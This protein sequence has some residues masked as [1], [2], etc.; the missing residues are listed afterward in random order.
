MTTRCI[1]AIMISMKEVIV[2]YVKEALIQKSI[3]WVEGLRPNHPKPTIRLAY[4]KIA[5]MLELDV[6]SND[7]YER[8]YDHVKECDDGRRRNKY[9]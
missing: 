3:K 9:E 2:M 1:C 8:L 6:I 5:A 4:G 7:E